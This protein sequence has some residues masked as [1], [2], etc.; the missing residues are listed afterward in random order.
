MNLTI[1]GKHLT[2]N[3]KQY[4]ADI[5]REAGIDIPT[6]CRYEGEQ[7]GVCRL[8]MVKVSDSAR[9]VPSCSTKA[10]EGMEVTTDSDEIRSYRRTLLSMV[11]EHHDQ[12]VGHT[13]ERCDLEK[14]SS[15]YSA[16]RRQKNSEYRSADRSHPA[17]DFDPGLCIACR[18]CVIA[19]NDE[20]GNNVIAVTGR[21]MSV[22]I[23]FDVCEP[24]GSS[25]CVSC[26]ACVDVC[27]TGALIERDW[28]PA[29]RSVIST[30]PYC[31]VGCTIEYGVK[32]DRIIWAKGVAGD[33]ANEGKLCVKG[34]F[35]WEFESSADRL[36]HPLIR[37]EGIERGSLNGRDIYEVFRKASW[38]E[39]LSL[40][41]NK[42]RE[43][44][45]KYGPEMI[46]G[47]ASDRGTNEDVYAFQKF[48]RAT[49]GSDN[50]DQS[51][52]LCHA[53]SAA[54]LSYGLGAGASTNPIHDVLN[55]RTIMV[56]GSNTDRAH[57]VVSSYI[58][59]AARLGATL[60]VI[61]PRKVELAE[62]A[63]IFLQLKP[64]SDA[65]LFSAMARYILEQGMQDDR[66]LEM[67]TENL[68]EYRRSLEPFDLV[69]AEKITGISADEIALVATAYAKEKPSSIY[70]TL[71]IT[72]H[73]NGSDNVSSLVN[74]AIITGNLGIPGGGL[75][76]IRGQNNVQGGADVGGTSG[77]LPGY[78]DLLAEEVR[79]KFEA[80]WK[81]PLP[82]KVGIKSTE[83]IQRALEGK[84]KMMYITGENS[85]RSHPDSSE[86]ERALKRLEFLVVQDLFMTET[87]EFAD[88]VF[89]AA[90]AF[91]KTG[92]FT[93]TERR[94][95][96]VRKILDPPGDAREDWKIYADL[97]EKLGHGLGFRNTSEIMDEISMLVPSW[98]GVTH[99]RLEHGGLSWPVT[100]LKSTGTG[101]LHVDHPVRHKA[102]LRPVSWV[103]RDDGGYPYLLI[104]GRKRE[105][106]HTATMTSRSHVISR[107]TE[108]PFLE[109]NPD[110]LKAEG[111]SDGDM[112]DV[113]SG[114]GRITC[115]VKG[116]GNLQRGVTFTTFHFP[117]LRANVLTPS[118]FDPITKTPAYKDA[119]IRISRSKGGH[120]R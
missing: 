103:P 50:L 105:Q 80:E 68:E 10:K 81:A 118:V 16:T 28:E 95:Q 77:S 117:E 29:D 59:K 84:L 36:L 98:A 74:L 40:V 37:K 19:C 3:G 113:E 8:C 119:R 93:N 97:A 62:Q 22:G 41:A 17:I 71:G 108:G 33:T 56:V 78:Q 111:L 5:A 55:S 47:I 49:I 115:R 52:T 24:M 21:G 15:I 61:D 20:Q 11:M 120:R 43:T 18:K 63:D 106:Y 44:A 104:T 67:N 116:S 72:E 94:I 46:G 1:D 39:A 13:R 57:P 6:L 27:P 2:V 12:H 79:K 75:N 7:N 38:E 53:P 96:M 90:S 83:M 101:I 89:P 51:A 35:G 102:R 32:G 91:E 30:C 42:I 70:W 69:T 82:S 54:M 110:D 85:V 87:A 86:V 76:P 9:L 31:G 109:M 73:Q 48:M 14:Y 4:I 92:T 100:D 66:Y 25:S 114:A 88:V 64:G 60:I 107:I 112:V 65:F 34:K 26:G 58:K 23:T 45:Q 99:S